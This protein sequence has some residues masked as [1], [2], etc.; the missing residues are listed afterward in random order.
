MFTNENKDQLYFGLEAHCDVCGRKVSD[1]IFRFNDI[2]HAY[3]CLVC[4]AVE[5][6]RYSLGITSDVERFSIHNH[7]QEN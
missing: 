7:T 4:Y 5:Q 6:K 3:I 2:K 1:I